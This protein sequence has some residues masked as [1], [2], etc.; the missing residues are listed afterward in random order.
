[1]YVSHAVSIKL[2][3]ARLTL[4]LAELMI[5]YSIIYIMCTNEGSRTY[6]HL[7]CTELQDVSPKVAT[8]K[9]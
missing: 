1:M 5:R 3:G 7:K 8:I 2:S 4:Y 9:A 6:L